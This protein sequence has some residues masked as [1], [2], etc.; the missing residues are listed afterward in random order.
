MLI[1]GDDS[2][3]VITLGTCFLFVYILILFHYI[4]IGG[5][6][7]VQSAGS[8]KGIVSGIQIPDT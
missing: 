2:N 7:T 8:H 4:L 5:K 6:L 1:S 3:E